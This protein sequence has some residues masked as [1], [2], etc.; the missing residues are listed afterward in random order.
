[1]PP[2]TPAVVQQARPVE[3]TA[4]LESGKRLVRRE[5]G[6]LVE[7]ETESDNQ[8]EQRTRDV[9]LQREAERL[10]LLKK[11]A[12][13]LE[14][15]RRDAERQLA[16]QRAAR[17][18]L[19]RKARM[20]KKRIQ[21][22]REAV[23]KVAVEREHVAKQL[24]QVTR[25]VVIERIP[26]EPVAPEPLPIVAEPPAAPV[27]AA[28]PPVASLEPVAVEQPPVQAAAEPKNSGEVQFLNNP[29]QGPTARFMST[30]R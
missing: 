18:A 24:S 14:K 4:A 17:E 25:P 8:D 29:C 22:A 20:E 13:R 26:V 5:D 7:A 11:E 2:V 19:E 28:E 1:L 3:S 21:A 6:T 12:L 27:G 23:E 10:A 9:E 30:C 15:E 16:R